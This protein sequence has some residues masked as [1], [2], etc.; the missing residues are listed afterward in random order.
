MSYRKPEEKRGR[1]T[2]YVAPESD[3][4]IGNDDP[5]LVHGSQTEHLL[6]RPVVL[7]ITP[8]L[9]L[10]ISRSEDSTTLTLQRLLPKHKHCLGSR[11]EPIQLYTSKHGYVYY[12]SS[13]QGRRPKHHHIHPL[14][15]KQILGKKPDTAEYSFIDGD[16][17]NLH[18]SNL[19]YN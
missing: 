17:A 1:V 4:D 6:L 2:Q 13:I 19:R 15:F 9:K 12:I 3:S 10:T 8:R 7:Y 14:V 16:K 18:P 11:H 5:L